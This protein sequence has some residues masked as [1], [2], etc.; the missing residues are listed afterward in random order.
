[1]ALP[2]PNLE[3]IG[4]ADPIGLV[5]APA[6]LAR[7]GLNPPDETRADS[8][9]VRAL[10]S[11]K[12]SGAMLPDAWTFFHEILGWRAAEVAGAPDGPALPPELSVAVEESDTELRPHGL[13]L[14]RA[15]AGSF[16][17]A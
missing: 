13:S 6:V 2:D 7:Y 8:E 10:L 1:M 4:N 16:L 9:A 12:A 15:A 17:S 11:G 3:W 5:V 14:R